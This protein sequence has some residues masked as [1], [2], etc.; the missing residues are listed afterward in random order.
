MISLPSDVVVQLAVD[1]LG[2][3]VLKDLI[4]TKEWNEY[5]F[6]LAIG[7]Q[8]SG[9]AAEAVAEAYA[10]LKAR[11]FVAPDPANLSDHGIFVT[12]TGRRV[13]AEGEDA[14]HVHERLQVGLHP[15][16][17]RKVRRQFMLGEYE[18][19]VFV[20]MKAVETR[21]RSLGSFPDDLGGFSSRGWRANRSQHSCC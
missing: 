14:L 15:A 21:V 10:W 3:H 8:Y 19:G 1:E 18:Q 12:R 20:A 16:I 11:A 4:A 9:D 17:D 5:N 7:R 2:L 13:A 6:R